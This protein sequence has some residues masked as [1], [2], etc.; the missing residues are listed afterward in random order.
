VLFRSREL[1]AV[2][3]FVAARSAAAVEGLERIAPLEAAVLE[4][5]R[6][7]VRAVGGT[8]VA[9]AT[10]CSDGRMDELDDR[11][12]RLELSSRK[13]GRLFAALATAVQVREP[14]DG[15]SSPPDLSRNGTGATAPATP[16]GPSTP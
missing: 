16:R 6:D 7:L 13:A 12:R 9:C 2:A 8:N 3:E 1:D 4:L 11:V 14:A 15:S 10:G 5:R